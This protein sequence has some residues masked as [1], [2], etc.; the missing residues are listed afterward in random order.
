MLNQYSLANT[1]VTYLAGDPAQ[2]LRAASIQNDI[3]GESPA[4]F[5]DAMDFVD[6]G[7]DIGEAMHRVSDVYGVEITI[8]NG[9][10][11]H[12]GVLQFDVGVVLEAADCAGQ[13]GLCAACRRPSG[14][15]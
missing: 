2:W 6:G 8:G 3:N 13:H 12:V 4:W 11:G 10:V 1:P 15:F 7:I 14:S 9:Q 5:H